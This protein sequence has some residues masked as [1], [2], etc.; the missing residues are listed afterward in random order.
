MRHG[1]A[2]EFGSKWPPAFVQC[3][4]ADCIPANC[5]YLDFNNEIQQPGV[6]SRMTPAGAVFFFSYQVQD[7]DR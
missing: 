4:I 5:G 1:S 3:K 2:C 6:A 7:F